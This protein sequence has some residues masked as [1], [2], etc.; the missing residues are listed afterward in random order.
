MG[1]RIQEIA[2]LKTV[3]TLLMETHRLADGDEAICS[4]LEA[5]LDL[6]FVDLLEVQSA[7]RPTVE[8]EPDADPIEPYQPIG[9]AFARSAPDATRRLGFGSPPV[10]RPVIEGVCPRRP[11]NPCRITT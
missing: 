11:E 2:R 8:Q 5:A 10:D 4:K 7:E 9:G 3:E 1:D 6:I